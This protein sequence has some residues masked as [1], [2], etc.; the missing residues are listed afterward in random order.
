M[1]HACERLTE[2]RFTHGEILRARPQE[3]ELGQEVRLHVEP[4]DLQPVATVYVPVQRGDRLARNAATPS[5]KS[6]L[7]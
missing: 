5:L 6:A 4:L 3:P 1:R 7:L 2:S